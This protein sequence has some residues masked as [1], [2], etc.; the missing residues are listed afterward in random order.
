MR[1]NIEVATILV[2]AKIRLS[3]IDVGVCQDL[4]WSG[5]DNKSMQARC[6]QIK[7]NSLDNTIFGKV[8]G[9]T[10]RD[11]HVYM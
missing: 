9:L 11:S 5:Y 10:L 3:S 4:N 7:K 1:L 6:K 2:I 8:P